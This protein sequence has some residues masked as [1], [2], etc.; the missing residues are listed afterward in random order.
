MEIFTFQTPKLIRVEIMRLNQQLLTV[1]GR[2][3]R[4]SNVPE[5]LARRRLGGSVVPE[6]VTRRRLGGSVDPGRVALSQSESRPSYLDTP[7]D[8]S[9]LKIQLLSL[10]GRRVIGLLRFR[11]CGSSN[12]KPRSSKSISRGK[13]VNRSNPTLEQPQIIRGSNTKEEK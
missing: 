5:L 8:G 3:L 10:L 4:G 9:R 11:H 6:L 12:D 1:T 13:L 7:T 2:R